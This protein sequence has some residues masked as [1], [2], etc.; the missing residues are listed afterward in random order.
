MPDIIPENRKWWVLLAIGTGTFMT[1]LD[2]S[3][4]NTVLPVIK[5]HFQS[6]IATVEWV[7]M[8]YLLLV[9]G[10]LPVFGRLGDLKGHKSIYLLGFFI[11]ILSS[12]SCSLARSVYALIASRG[13]QAL[14]AAMLSANSPAI[15]TKSFPSSQRGQALGMQ[16]TMTYLGLSVGPSLG[17]WLTELFSW[18]T[19]FFINLPVGVIAFSL[20]TIFILNDGLH[21][22]TEGFDF[23][24]AITL[25]CGLVSLLLGL[26]QGHNWGWGSWQTLLC[27][28]SSIVLLGI[29]ILLERRNP[30]PMLDLSLFTCPQ[31][32]FTV[33]SAILNYICVYSSIFLL[34]FYLIQGRG[35]NAAQAGLYL[36][37]QPLVMAV[38]APVSGTLSDKIGTRIPT[39]IGMGIMAVGLY[40][41]SGIGPSTSIRILLLYLVIFGLGI[42]I[43]ISPNNSALMGSAPKNRQGIAAGLLATARN[44][45]MVLGI[46]LAGAIFNTTLG[47]HNSDNPALLY[48]AIRYSYFATVIVAIIGVF[49]SSIKNGRQTLS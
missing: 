23:S 8:I 21:S 20:S 7:V 32:S 10:L 17:G 14:G 28:F 41:L 6:N 40:F 18:R 47:S 24:G 22:N 49:I 46:G 11:F 16:A 29:F 48:P 30:H 44:V 31:F 38:I 25:M 2:T 15:I 43:F 13:I 42:G 3:V 1:A 26:N 37:A 39:T 36:T 27:I 45:G 33:T 5:N 35:F 12:V 9:S 4:V 34:P 19:V